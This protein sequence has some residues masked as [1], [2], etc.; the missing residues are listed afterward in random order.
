[1]L[2]GE[3]Y[4]HCV[5]HNWGFPGSSD[6]KEFI[7]NAGDVGST[8]GQGRSTGEENANPFQYFCLE[9]PMDGGAFWGTVH[10]VPGGLQSMESQRQIALKKVILE[11]N[12]QGN[13]RKEQQMLFKEENNILGKARVCRILKKE[14]GLV[15][16]CGCSGA[17]LC[18][19]L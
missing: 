1:M 16:Y 14:M 6:G 8:P 3:E 11:L 13:K 9:N 7:C 12:H 2:T 17:Q 10:W 5:A 18:L 19:T 4:T 15:I